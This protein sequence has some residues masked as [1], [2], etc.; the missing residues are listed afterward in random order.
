MLR[1]NLDNWDDLIIGLEQ[2][3]SAAKRLRNLYQI[4]NNETPNLEGLSVRGMLTELANRNGG[5][6]VVKDH[7][8]TIR[9][10]LK[11]DR[12]TARNNIYSVLHTASN[13]FTHI[14]KG[15]YQS[16]LNQEEK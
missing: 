3:L 11:V 1:E 15:I 6:L 16:K 10:N 14:G 8:N 5:K 2:S 13:Y 7:I 4:K 12:E 9:A